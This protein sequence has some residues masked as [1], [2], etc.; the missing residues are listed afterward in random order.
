MNKEVLSA[1][2]GLVGAVNNNGKTTQTDAIV[3]EAFLSNT[4][5]M[6]VDKLHSEKYNISPNCETCQSPCGNTSDYPL[7]KYDQWSIEQSEVKEQII[8]ES[9]RIAENVDEGVD[10]P[11]ILYRAIAYLGYDLNYESYNNLLEELRKW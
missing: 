9:R 3:R 7:E 1:L 4:D 5:V 10:L 11:D 6:M 8:D 2:I